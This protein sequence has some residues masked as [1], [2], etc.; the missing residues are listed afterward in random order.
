MTQTLSFTISTQNVP[1]K[2]E[3]FEL[4]NANKW[5]SA[6][7]LD[8]L[9]QA[10][11]NSETLVTAHLGGKLVG[12]ANAI[13]DKSL[14]VYFPHLLIHPDYH[15]MGVGSKIMDV[16]LEKYKG[17][18]QQMIVADNT[19]VDFYKKKGFEKATATT[20]MWIYEGDDH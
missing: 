4:Y 10:L 17:F 14:V 16:M 6:F 3:L 18:H 13:S 1:S 8:L 9:H 11:V 15:K 12:L 20:S 19:A 2:Q 5:S 7:K